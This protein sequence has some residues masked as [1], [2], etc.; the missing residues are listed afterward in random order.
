MERGESAVYRFYQVLVNL[1][2]HF[3]CKQRFF[4]VR[5]EFSGF[6][7]K[8]ELFY[9]RIKHLRKRIFEAVKGRINRLKRLTAY[10]YVT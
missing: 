9:L 6:S 8:G 10:I 7:E 3:V 1:N 2:R 4:D 5:A